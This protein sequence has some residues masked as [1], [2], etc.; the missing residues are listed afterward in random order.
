MFDG[1]LSQGVLY[2][3]DDFDP[4]KKYPVI[5]NYYEQLS[6][7]LHE[8]PYPGVTGSNINIPWFVSRGYLVFT[9]DIHYKV[10]ADKGGRT[11]GESAYNS[12]VSAAGYLA[13]LPYVDGKKMAI[14]GH[15]FGGFQTNYLVTHSHVFAAACEM[16]G[17]SDPVSNYLLIYATGEPVSRLYTAEQGQVRMGATLWERP[18]LYFKN[19][20]VLS[21]NKTTTPLLIVHN[22]NDHSVQWQ[23]GVEI[24]MALR[25]LG[26]PSWM[27]QYDDAGHSIV[28]DKS[29]KDYTLRLT[30]FFDHYLKNASAPAWMTQ[31]ML[32][33]YK[34]V[35]DL[36]EPV[37]GGSCSAS[38]KVC[39]EVNKKLAKFHGGK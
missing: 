11:Y 8:F 26:K 38:C 31:S 36:Y 17:E 12:V 35:A 21:A 3:P 19:S 34:G 28:S 4:Q 20:A 22:K 2:K 7:R 24:Y 16:A 32:S 18:D 30:A 13:K 1:Q 6:H 25:R 37:P 27:L 5:F 10:A 15:S 14:Q 33:K 39:Q 29:A 9:P 23:Q